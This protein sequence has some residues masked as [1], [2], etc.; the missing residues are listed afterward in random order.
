M[1]AMNLNKY[2]EKAQESVVGS[3][4]LAEQSGHPLIEPEHLL[5]ALAE[6]HEGIVPE[7]LRKMSAYGARPLKRTLQRRVLDALAMRILEGEFVEGDTVTVDALAD[8]L[9]FEKR[10]A[11]AA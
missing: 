8:G 1:I 6:Q 9:R 5:V 10:P 4:Q 7:V 2:T 11:V 3:Q